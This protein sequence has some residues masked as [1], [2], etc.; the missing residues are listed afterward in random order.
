MEVL[1]IKV[2]HVI[3]NRI[4]AQQ[5]RVVGQDGEQ[6]GVMSRT[7]ALDL[8]TEQNFDL[9]LIAPK[10]NP[11]VAKI[12]DYGKFRFEAQKREKE[13]KK[14]QKV[15][16]LKE[17]RLSPTIEEHDIKVRVKNATKFLEQGN[18]LKVSIRFKG[19]QMAHTEVGYVVMKD[20][21]QRLEGI[22]II[23]RRAM[24]EGRSMSMIM[25]AVTKK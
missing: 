11:P 2:E 12:M 21:A 10:A 24:M 14:K 7:E 25:S 17:V 16:E 4:I 8:A 15:I 1:N 19:R 6:L 22:A 13:A 23:E 20:F 3:N 9:V 5:L 18:K